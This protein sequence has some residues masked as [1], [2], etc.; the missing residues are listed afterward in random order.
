ADKFYIGQTSEIQER[1]IRHNEG[2]ADKF[3]LRYRPWSIF[4][5]IHCSSREDAINEFLT[6]NSYCPSHMYVNPVSLSI[7]T[8][9]FNTISNGK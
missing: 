7:Q 8:T 2:Q 5:L 3:T 9:P 1:L 6:L 4:H